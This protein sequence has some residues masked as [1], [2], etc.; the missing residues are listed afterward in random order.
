MASVVDLEI[1]RFDQP[2]AKDGH[3][4]LRYTAQGSHCGEPYKGVSETGRHT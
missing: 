3:V 1:I 4:P 2:W